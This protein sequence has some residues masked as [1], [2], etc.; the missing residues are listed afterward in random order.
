MYTLIEIFDAK[1][2]ENIIAPVI[3]ENVSK[4]IYLGSE[5][6]MTNDK[7]QN[8]KSFFSGRS[9]SPVFEFFSVTRDDADSISSVLG[10]IIKNN[11][12]CVFDVTGGEDAIL[13]CVGIFA[14]R[15]SVPVIR[16]DAKSGKFSLVYGKF[17][18]FKT[19]QPEL[20]TTDFIT[21]QGAKILHSKSLNNL[22]EKQMR[23]IK[24]LFDVNAADCEAYS[25]FCNFAAEH[26]SENK[27]LL[28]FNP[29]ILGKLRPAYVK[30]IKRVLALLCKK[31]LLKENKRYAEY[32]IKNDIIADSLKKAGDV[33]ENYTALATLNL[34]EEYSDIRVGTSV[35]WNKRDRLNYT[36]N[37][38]DVLA[39]SDNLPVFISC[40]NGDVKKE[41][42]YELDTVSRGLGGAY[43]KKILVCTYISKNISAREHFIS[44]ARDMG[45]RLVY[46][47]DKMS[48][49]EFLNCMKQVAK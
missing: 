32:T 6:I 41:S 18:S 37:E 3:L 38:I 44:R 25:I 2:Y 47:V 21:L 36:Q 14:C 48:F 34:P 4:V 33:L 20:S 28:R 22:S 11:Q 27:K 39:V 46:D 17:T 42:L 29:N 13:V 7:I 19:K 9:S 35:E 23:D 5:K 1:Q 15:H 8:L 26:I 24:T 43:V 49:D 31:Y 12:N 45:I 16:I 10:K 40:K 30:A